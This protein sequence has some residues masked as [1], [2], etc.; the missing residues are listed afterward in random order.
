MCAAATSHHGKRQRRVTL[1]HSS[2][3]PDN[4]SDARP[5]SYRHLYQIRRFNGDIIAQ[6][7]PAPFHLLHCCVAVLSTSCF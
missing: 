4:R 2:R 1:H 7:M 6:V 5:A 3:E